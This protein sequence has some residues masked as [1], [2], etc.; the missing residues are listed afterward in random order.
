MEK[1]LFDKPKILI[2]DDEPRMCQSLMELLAGHN[3]ELNTANSAKEAI[4]Y[5]NKNYFDL[6]LLNIG[7]PD[8]DGFQVMDHINRQSPKTLIIVMTGHASMESAVKALRKGAYDYLRKPFEPEK[9]LTT[10]KI[11][12][13]QQKVKKD[14]ELAKEALRENEERFRSIVENTNA[15]YFFID[16]D[17][18]IQDVNES[19]IKMYGYSSFDEIVG[20]HFTIIQK[21]EDVESAKAFVKGI[22]RK[23]HKYMTGEFS[24][25][26]KDGSIGYHTFSARPVS[27]FGEVI[28]IEGFIIDSTERKLLEKSLQISKKEWES[29]FDA[30]SDWVSVIDLDHQILRSNRSGE[31]FLSIP[32]GEMIGQTCY[33]LVHGSE[34]PIP[35]CPLQKML[36]THE[37]ETVDLYVQEMNRWLRVSI[38]PIMDEDGNLTKAVHIVRD[39]TEYKEMEAEVLKAK[40]LESLGTLAGGIAHDFNNLLSVIVGNIELAKDGI[41]YDLD[42]L[43]N[44]KEVEKASIRASDLAAQLITFA[45]GGKPIK[46]AASIGEL[47]KNAVSASLSG[48]G[49]NCEFSIP[50][51]LFPVEID[52]LQIKQVIRNIVI[53]ATEAMNGKGIINVYC[54]NAAVGEKDRLPLK[55][56]KYV[57]LSIKDQGIGIA[58]ENL[59]KIFDPYYSTKDMGAD[60]GQGLGLATCHS[61]IKKHDGFITAESELAVGTT[62]F[63]YLP[64]SEKK[65]IAPEPIKKLV[66]EKPEVGRGKILMMDDERMLRNLIEQM[67]SPFGYDVA[68]AQD[69][70]EAVELYRSAM[71]SGKP[72]DAVI[73]DLTVKS[74]MGGKTAVQK[75][76]EIN[77]HAKAIVSSGYFNDPVMT[78]Y[79]KYGFAAALPKPFTLKALKDTLSKVLIGKS[80]D[81]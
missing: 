31:K 21:M 32:L 79:K 73:L 17:G 66:S 19:W 51:D 58:A 49:I 25:K 54:E 14:G 69:G 74:G 8:M 29:T 24:R 76:L 5:L 56:G 37:H 53:N 72:F 16:R 68:L 60:K 50:D 77:P 59:L 55:A 4:E 80:A 38:D 78:D 81:R 52:A 33:K 13:N 57:L 42:V 70:T 44:L 2:V 65:M 7:L 1:A 43:D 3:Y 15:G 20:K 30:M 10:V 40:K 35:E 46:K 36:Q 64:A 27:H 61:I 48:S 63:V 62:L 75:L 11:A 22:M 28:G 71:E 12:L 26:C 41:K 6:I 67:L 23:D 34:E 18:L 9:L 45:K 39:I 47:V